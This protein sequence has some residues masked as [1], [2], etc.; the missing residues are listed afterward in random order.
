MCLVGG[1]VVVPLLRAP[2]RALLV[3]PFGSTRRL[4]LGTGVRGRRGL[5]TVVVRGGLLVGLGKGTGTLATGL[6]FD[7]GM[8]S[9]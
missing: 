5:V 7:L 6:W 8:A 9:Q 3:E 1:W 2:D 4:L